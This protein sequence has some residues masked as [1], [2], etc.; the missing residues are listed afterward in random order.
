MTGVGI[1]ERNFEKTLWTRCVLFDLDG[2]LYESP[3][4]SLRLESEIVRFIS[5]QLGLDEGRARSMLES[6]KK[7]LGTLT[8][9]IQSL[10]IDRE[11]FFHEIADRI[12][13]HSYIRQD[14]TALS[15]LRELKQR[16]FK[17]GL[18]SNSGRVLVTKILD[19]LGIESSSFDVIVTSSE[20]EPKPSPQPFLL[21]MKKVGCDGSDSVYVGDREDAE[22]LPAK[23]SGL[24][25]ILLDRNRSQVSSAADVVVTSLAQVP[26]VVRLRL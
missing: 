23:R 16:G 10:G 7:E 11:L 5:E 20:A 25:T 19:A 4:Y 21:A 13:P 9:T 12:E 1:E 24:R 18:V 14:P 15:V 17:M 8:R 22:V 26:R 2:T 6:R 3:E